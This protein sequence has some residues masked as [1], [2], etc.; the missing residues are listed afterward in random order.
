MSNSLWPSGL[1][2]T[3][4]LSLWDSLGKN[5]GVDCHTLPQG[6]FLNQG[7]DLQLSRQTL[8]CWATGEAWIRL[9][10]MS[11]PHFQKELN[12]VNIL[13][14]LYEVVKQLRYPMSSQVKVSCVPLEVKANFLWE[15]VEI[16]TEQS[17]L[18]KSTAA[19][20]LI[21]AGGMKSVMS[22]LLPVEPSQLGLWH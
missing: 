13:K 11:Y 4:L 14:K 22:L 6:I 16:G 18:A 21:L 17:I 10:T 8:Y 19:K 3:R 1:Q 7:L 2:L 9:Y 5:T 20:Y 15:A 12:A